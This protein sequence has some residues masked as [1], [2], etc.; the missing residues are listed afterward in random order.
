[1]DPGGD[2]AVS[3]SPPMHANSTNAMHV[4]S[5]TLPPTGLA[6]ETVPPLARPS[7][8][9]KGKGPPPSIRTPSTPAAK[10]VR[11]DLDANSVTPIL[12]YK[13]MHILYLY[14]GDPSRAD[15]IPEQLRKRGCMVTARDL[16]G[17]CNLLDDTEWCKIDKGVRTIYDFVLMSPPCVTFA[18]SRGKGSGPRALRSRSE[19][20]GMKSP[21]PPFTSLETEAVKH[22]NYHSVQCLKL[23]LTCIEVRVGFAIECP[24]VVY[25][26]Q[27][28]MLQFREATL[29]DGCAGVVDVTTDQCPFGSETKKPTNFKV[30]TNGKI[31]SWKSV[32]GQHCNHPPQL[33]VSLDSSGN[34]WKTWRPHQKLIGRHTPDGKWATAAAAA[35]PTRLNTALVLLM[36]ESGVAS[37]ALAEP[38]R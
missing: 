30:Y 9:A 34:E 23:G 35:Y 8:F 21:V 13:S 1:L 37:R 36:L 2:V 11:W 31:Q 28:S 19:V 32:L 7:A 6:T 16:V 12:G 33:W 25:D 18:H 17:G 27:V 3:D 38:S 15:G 20:Y 5:N 22:G 4:N 10:R 29:L 14:C 24:E 26:D